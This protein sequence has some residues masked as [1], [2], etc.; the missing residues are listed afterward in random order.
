M[1]S[2]RCT[3]EFLKRCIVGEVHS[4]LYALTAEDRDRRRALGGN[5]ALCLQECTESLLDRNLQGLTHGDGM[6]LDRSQQFI[7][8]VDGVRMYETLSDA[9]FPCNRR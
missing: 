5:A 3:H 7:V 4:W 8:D 2:G 1:T 9:K 6:D